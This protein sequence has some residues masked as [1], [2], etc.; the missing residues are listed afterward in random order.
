VDGRR[1][2]GIG[3]YKW[4]IEVSGSEIGRKWA[5]PMGVGSGE[6]EGVS[7]PGFSC[8]ILIR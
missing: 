8:M 7:L 6:Q 3:G 2:I 5:E 4:R 1:V